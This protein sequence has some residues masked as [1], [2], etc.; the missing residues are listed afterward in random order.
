MEAPSARE[1]KD[2]LD[3]FS[4]GGL[5][6]LLTSYQ[7]VAVENREGTAGVICVVGNS[8][9]LAVGASITK[10]SVAGSVIGEGPGEGGRVKT[11][12]GREIGCGQLKIVNAVVKAHGPI[13]NH[14]TALGLSGERALPD[15]WVVSAL[16]I[17]GFASFPISSTH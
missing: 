4:A 6:F 10:G 16:G 13:L 1:G 3:D 9:S 2:R 8:S 7:A 11:L 12:G 15:Q 14:I 5:H 17:S